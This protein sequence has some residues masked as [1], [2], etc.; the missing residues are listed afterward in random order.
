VS[1]GLL[2]PHKEVDAGLVAD[3]ER[4][5]RVLRPE[6][7][8][9]VSSPYEWSFGELKEAALA[10]LDAQRIALDHG[11]SMRDASA[12]NVQFRDGRPILIDTL[13]FE[14]LTEGAP[15]VAYAQFCRHFLAPLALMRHRDVR[16]GHLLREHID[17]LPLDLTAGLMPGRARLRPGLLLHLFLHA[18]AQRSRAGAAPA[19]RPR[20][21]PRP[22]GP[23]ALRG[24]IQ[25]LE[26]TVHSLSWEPDRTVWSEYYSEAGSYM[27]AGLEIERRE[28]VNACST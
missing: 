4:A 13:S 15:W 26:R 8:R 2:V 19:T 1:E 25:S 7:I 17:G 9:F 27:D 20:R 10:T 28:P 3:P 16:L 5:H 12:F 11:M 24:V 14:R 18:R 23:N 22:V 6:V 21:A